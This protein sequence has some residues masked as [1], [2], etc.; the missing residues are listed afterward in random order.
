MPMGT[1]VHRIHLTRFASTSFNPCLG[2]PTRFAPIQDLHGNCVPSLYAGSNLESVAF[3][4]LF[5]EVGTRGEIKTVPVRSLTER[6]HSVI[7][8]KR[9]LIFAQLFAPDLKPWQISR[10]SLIGTSPALYDATA[11]W[12]K[13]IHHQFP[14]IDGLIWTS[15]QCDPERA[16]LF[17]GDRV[18]ET[19]FDVVSARDGTSDADFLTDA[20]QAALRASVYFI[21]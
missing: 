13:A 8:T 1:V 19:D 21:V 10:Q 16:Y 9:D 4:T 12:A 7:Q 3:E 14:T 2:R 17:Y 20:R 5:H 15:N 6:T 11:L 18:A